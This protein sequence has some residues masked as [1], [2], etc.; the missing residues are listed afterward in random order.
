[1]KRTTILERSVAALKIAL[2]HRIASVFDFWVSPLPAAEL[3]LQRVHNRVSRCQ[4]APFSSALTAPIRNLTRSR[5]QVLATAFVAVFFAACGNDSDG[6]SVGYL[7][8]GGLWRGSLILT[9][10]TCQ[11]DLAPSY[12]LANSVSQSFN[13]IELRDNENRLFVGDLVGGDGF[14][15]D[16]LGPSNER[17]GDGRTCSLTYR[18]RYDSINDDGDRTAQVRYLIVGECSDGSECQSEYAG[19]GLRG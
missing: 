4:S 2:L 13:S 3:R 6:D 17:I 19:D 14:S 15:V 9:E 7:Y 10:N 18:Y 16:T 12:T 1:M 8:V 5:C 11:L